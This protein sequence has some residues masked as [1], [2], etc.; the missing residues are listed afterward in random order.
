MATVTKR[1]WTTAAGRCKEAWRV[2]YVDQ[3]GQTRTRQFDK[4]KEADAFRI[5]AEGEVALG[6]HTA[7]RA[8]VTVTE[9]SDIHIA[10]AEA[11]KCSRGTIK[12][13][14]EIASRHIIPLIG[15]KK[16]S[17]L[18]GPS[19]V[20]F[21]DALIST[22]SH[23]MAS[24]AL[25]QLSTILNEAQ[26]RGLVAQNVARG[27]KVRRARDIGEK[28]L[29]KRA[30]IPTKDHLRAM[31][32]AADRLSNEDP[33]L[34]V[35]LRTVMLTG[36][37]ASELRGLQ[38]AAVNLKGPSLSVSQSA[39]RWNELGPPKSRAGH[40]TIPIGPGLTTALKAWKLRCP[41]S[42]LNLVFPNRPAGRQWP[43]SAGRAGGGPIKQHTMAALLLKVQVAASIAIDTGKRT[44][45]GEPVWKLRYDWHHL[46]H[47]AASS[48]LNDGI[49][50]KRLQVWIGHENIQL[51]LDVY[52]HLVAD[53]EK[54]AALA[55]G[56]EASLLG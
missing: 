36:L 2:R 40:R 47:V 46:R 18:D 50:L 22:R 16:L 30:E 52:G 48:W 9:A 42:P 5:K 24:K 23:A 20:A 28:S 32:A 11:A 49:D 13:Y 29:A 4:K 41:P 34:P 54:D 12:T 43:S 25:R 15:D 38:W 1:S 55:A 35:M 53:A 21:R 17:R 37:R 31:L 44:D 8:S 39:D 26:G 51:T 6:V 19:V 27:V 3:H 7:D 45:D 56:A 33:R 14:R 10:A